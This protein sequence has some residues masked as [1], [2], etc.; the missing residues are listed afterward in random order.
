[1]P[2]EIAREE[3]NEYRLEGG[4]TVRIK[5]VVHKIARVL[6]ADDKPDYTVHGEPFVFVQ[7]HNAVVARE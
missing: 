1:M 4:G 7:S 5:T 6:D 3:W 2:F